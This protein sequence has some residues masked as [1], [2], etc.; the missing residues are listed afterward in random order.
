MGT[1]MRMYARRKGRGLGEV[2]ITLDQEKDGKGAL[3]Q[4][5]MHIELAGDLSGEERM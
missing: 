1:T 5:K 2:N 3:A 4:I